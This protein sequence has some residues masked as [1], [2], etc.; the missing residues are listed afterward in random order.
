[1][2]G[3]AG[4]QHGWMWLWA[5]ADGMRSGRGCGHEWEREAVVVLAFDQLDMV[6]DAAGDVV[7][8]LAVMVI[9]AM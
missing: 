3:G 4:L 8:V 9:I 7:A 1:M 6:V 2:G 5:R